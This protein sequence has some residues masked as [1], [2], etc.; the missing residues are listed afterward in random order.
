[1]VAARA[2]HTGTSLIPPLLIGL[3]SASGLSINASFF[4]INMLA[5]IV[6]GWGVYHFGRRY[7]SFTPEV[8]AFVLFLL[9][10]NQ[11][12][13][14]SLIFPQTDPVALAMVMIALC[15]NYRVLKSRGVWYGVLLIVNILSFFTKLSAL[16]VWGLPLLVRWFD[17]G[18]GL[19]ARIKHCAPAFAHVMLAAGC[20][21]A[22]LWLLGL[23]GSLEDEF[24]SVRSAAA[25]HGYDKDSNPLR[26]LL[27][28]IETLQLTGLFAIL[29]WRQRT[30]TAVDA[31]LLS[32]ALLFLLSLVVLKAAFWIRYLLP[33]LPLV[34]LVGG[35]AIF[36]YLGRSVAG[37]L[38]A[39]SLAV[40]NAL[41]LIYG[42]YY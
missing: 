27:V 41:F 20:S 31:V 5:W 40:V 8:A 1:M 6:V 3:A 42:L 4:L 32:F 29:R 36:R 26:L 23:T 17:A 34:S 33:M 22:L 19:K 35:P 37:Y 28:L 16:P 10:S 7:L 25:S 14:R 2:S 15:V 11:A 39:A 18:G 12:V 13:A 21:L 38:Y 9:F 30:L 24:E